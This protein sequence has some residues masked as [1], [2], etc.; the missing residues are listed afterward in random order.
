[1]KNKIVVA[2]VAALALSFVACAGTSEG[3]NG[4]ATAKTESPAAQ[5]KDAQYQQGLDNKQAM[6]ESMFRGFLDAV[7][8]GA[9]A[10]TLY[11]YLTDS[12]EYWLDTLEN[13]AKVYDS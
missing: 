13:H 4:G 7:R 10:D 8:S 3:T 12:S 9:P 1:M 11:A 6:L 5:E 2:L